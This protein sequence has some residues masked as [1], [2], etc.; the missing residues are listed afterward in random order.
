M[1]PQKECPD[2]GRM[3]PVSEPS[4]AFKPVPMTCAHERCPMAQ[5][6]D[7]HFE[8]GDDETGGPAFFWRNPWTGKREKIANLW[9]PEH[10]P[11]ATEQVEKL[12]ERLRLTAE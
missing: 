9:W 12:F 5:S 4:G 10:P 8:L 1:I 11:E 3:V 6:D 2:C 7:P